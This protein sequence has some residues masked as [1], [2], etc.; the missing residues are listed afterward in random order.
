[1]K[2]KLGHRLELNRETLCR[3]DLAQIQGGATIGA[4]C[5]ITAGVSCLACPVSPTRFTCGADCNA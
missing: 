3:I 2:R 5:V 1:M 4:G